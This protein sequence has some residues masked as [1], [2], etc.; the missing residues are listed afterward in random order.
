MS[1]CVS[2]SESGDKEPRRLLLGGGGERTNGSVRVHERYSGLVSVQR[3]RRV[4]SNHVALFA[5]ALVTGIDYTVLDLEC[6]T[7]NGLCPFLRTE[8]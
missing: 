2:S 5:F 7:D 1:V 4:E 6:E 3:S 8:L